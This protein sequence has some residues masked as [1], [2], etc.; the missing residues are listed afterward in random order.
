[1]APVTAESVPDE[2]VVQEAI[3][4]RVRLQSGAATPDDVDACRRWR[5][6]RADH[7]QAWARLEGLTAR[8]QTLP[9]RIAHATLGDATAVRRRHGRRD[10][11]KILGVLGAAGSAGWL[12]MSGDPPAAWRAYLAD[13]ATGTGERRT[14]TL[15]DGTRLDLNTRT[16]IDTRYDDTHRSVRL[17][18]GEVLVTTAP[19]VA[20]RHRPFTLHA[21]QGA[22][23]A[24]GTRFLV[25]DRDGT[26]LVA[27]Y[28]G[29]VEVRP[30]GHAGPLRVNAG[31]QWMF[32]GETSLAKTMADPDGMAWVDGVIVA[33]RLPLGSLVAQ[34]DRY[35]WGKFRCDPAVAH[36]EISGVFPLDD[37]ARVLAAIARTLPVRIEALTPY[38]I[39]VRAAG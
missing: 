38:W 1:M 10:A 19:D 33:R 32:G 30:L 37:P 21:R 14:L 35:Y 15:A 27:V 18:R 29:A 23:H 28:E 13:V 7:E 36:L 31:E 4:W 12:V 11:L 3:A 20:G 34:L 26:T 17:H 2:Q 8:V 9:S 24:L 6:A 5:A 16:A 39:T 22:I 25:Q